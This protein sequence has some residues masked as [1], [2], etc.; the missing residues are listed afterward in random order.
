MGA[1]AGGEEGVS[2]RDGKKITRRVKRK[3]HEH[4]QTKLL[5]EER[6]L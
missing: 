3:F 5:F 4:A 6:D 2:L 1:A